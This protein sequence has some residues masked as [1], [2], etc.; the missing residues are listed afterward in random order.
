MDATRPLPTTPRRLLTFV[1]HFVEMCI[2][3]CA[4]GVPLTLVLLA[5][6]GG[7]AFRTTYPEV[8]LVLIAA[9]LSGP[10][11]AWMLFRGMP[12]RPTVEMAAAS[13]VVV[14]ALI[15]AAAAGV[16]SSAATVT[17]GD[18]C[19]F[20][21]AAMLVVMAARFDLYSGGHHHAM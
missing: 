18:V 5:V 9:T 7:D 2:A 1:G 13:F 17:V 15:V 14:F 11:T 3:M 6:L 8:S 12:P 20:S 10:M 4:A 16:I 21:C 19:G